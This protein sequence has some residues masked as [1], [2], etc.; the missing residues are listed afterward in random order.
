MT[1]CRVFVWL[2]VNEGHV[3]ARG[4][5][6]ITWLASALRAA[7]RLKARGGIVWIARLPDA[8]V[9]PECRPIGGH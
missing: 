1:P 3:I 7:R 2:P 8:G 5:G 9:V 4:T 6:P